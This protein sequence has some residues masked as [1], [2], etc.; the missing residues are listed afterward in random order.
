[1]RAR[2]L[3]ILLVGCLLVAP[4]L[5][6]TGDEGEIELGVYAGQAS[7]DTYGGLNPKNDS[8]FGGRIGYWFTDVWGIEGSWQKLNTQTRFPSSSGLSD[9]DFDLTA[10]RANV[11]FNMR[12]GHTF[13]PFLTA[14]FGI[15][16]ATLDTGGSESDSQLNAGGGL[17]WMF[18]NRIGARLDGRWVRTSSSESQTDYEATLGFTCL[19]GGG[20]P[21]DADGDGVGDRKDK[22][23]DTPRGATVDEKGCPKDSDG[24][25]VLD[26]LDR[27]PDTPKGWAVDAQG[28]P[29]DSDGDGVPDGKDACPNTPKGAVVDDKGCPKDS[30]GDGVFDG[31]DRCPDTPKGVKVDDKGCPKDSDGDGVF[32]GPDRCPDTPR[33]DKV[34]ANGCTIVPPKAPLFQEKK[35]LV[36]EGVRFETDKWDILPEDIAI[37][38]SVAASLNDWPDVRV[39][40]A[41]HTDSTG[42]K[43]HNVELSDKRA[44]AVRDYLASKGVS[45]SRMTEKG[46]GD[47]EPVADNKTKEGRAQNRRV[48]LKKLD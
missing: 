9:I 47:T 8:L 1:M 18:S 45:M 25:G 38:D 23:P 12:P 48:E 42:G 43:Q 32:D 44:S 10:G 27:C 14:G 7:L 2:M 35:T 29:L 11:M 41:G 22:C 24:D 5:A 20:P 21:K 36:L 31:L 6:A 26:G 19:L 3:L 37:L 39:E 4:A 30:D 13:R 28:C 40:V 46:Y 17:R 34:D 33:G 16:K 15:G